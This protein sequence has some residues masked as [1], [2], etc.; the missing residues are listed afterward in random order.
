M[1]IPQYQCSILKE[2]Y[3]HLRIIAAS[4]LAG[5]DPDDTMLI[6]N[7]AVFVNMPS[8]PPIIY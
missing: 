8:Y 4:A 5:F 7:D 6:G 3:P 2:H 1:R